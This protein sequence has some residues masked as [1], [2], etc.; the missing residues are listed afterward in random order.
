MH[1]K[2]VQESPDPFFRVLVMQYIQR[3][4]NGRDLDARLEVGMVLLDSM[5]MGQIPII[6]IMIHEGGYSRLSHYTGWFIPM[7][8]IATQRA[9]VGKYSTW[10]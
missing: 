2:T 4:G 8:H 5:Y 7:P 1:T 6:V 9:S 10:M 3:C